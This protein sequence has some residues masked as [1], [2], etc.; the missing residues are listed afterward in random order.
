[1]P[2]AQNLLDADRRDAGGHQLRGVAVPEG[3]RGG[4]HIES[5]L[6]PVACHQVLDGANREWS[7]APVLKERSGRR[8]GEASRGVEGEKLA[9]AALGD[10]VEG[11]HAAARAFAD[12]RGEVE[13]LPGLAIARDEVRDEASAFPDAEPGVVQEEDEQV[14]PLAEG[15]GEIDGGED[16]PDLGL[17]Q[18]EHE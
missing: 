18:S 8:G 1:M 7:V 17:C 11:H 14:I 9:D 13:I 4:P 5:G 2:V 15:R 3:V 10:G 12:R 6:F 16:L